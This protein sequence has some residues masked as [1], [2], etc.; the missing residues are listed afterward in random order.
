MAL[1]KILTIAL[2]LAPCALATKEPEST[3]SSKRTSIQ[4][5]V[6]EFVN[7]AEAG[8]GFLKNIVEQNFQPN[9]LQ[10]YVGKMG[11]AFNAAE[12]LSSSDLPWITKYLNELDN[13]IRI[14]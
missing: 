5:A 9:E 6:D 10:S 1:S 2:L 8:A 3:E 11:L 4:D 7:E 14:I 12:K 13:S